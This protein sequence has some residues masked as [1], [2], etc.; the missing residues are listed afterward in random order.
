ML[1]LLGTPLYAHMFCLKD[2]MEWV[3]DIFL[4]HSLLELLDNAPPG[5]RQNIWFIY[6]D[7]PPHFSYAARIFHKTVC[8]GQW[9]ED[10][11]QYNK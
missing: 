4:V 10:T 1:F 8:T 5:I 11:D 3:T 6:G 2:S 9:V 7:T